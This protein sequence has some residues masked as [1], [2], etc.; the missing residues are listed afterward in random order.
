MQWDAIDWMDNAEC[1]DL[2]EKVNTLLSP[3]ET[4]QKLV[5]DCIRVTALIDLKC[6]KSG[7]DAVTLGFP[8]SLSETG[9]VGAGERGESISQRH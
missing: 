8:V 3:L 4:D 9:L 1:L 2:I 5:D 7:A 6:Q